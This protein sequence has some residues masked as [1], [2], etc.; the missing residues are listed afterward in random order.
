MRPAHNPD[1][2]IGRASRSSATTFASLIRAAFVRGFDSGYHPD[3]GNGTQEPRN[4]TTIAIK[5]L[6]VSY[7]R[8]WALQNLTGAFAAGA[9][10]AVVGPNGAG[11]STLIKALAGIVR[12]R[13][14]AIEGISHHRR[15]AYLPQQSGLDRGF[16]VT[17]GELV[18]LGG[19]RHFGAFRRAPS[20]IS[21]RAA[22]SIATVGLDGFATRPIAGLSVGQFQRALFA[23]LL[24]QE[25]DVLLLDEPFAAIDERT[26][27][28]LLQLLR[29]WHDEG[30]TI[31]AVLHDLTQVRAHFPMTLLLARRGIG[32]GETASVLTTE[33]L[34]RARVTLEG[35]A[36]TTRDVE[37]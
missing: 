19:W 35:E 24:M 32:W 15:F 6:S 10:T 31:I 11:K 20:E 33:N 34:A 5:D 36:D 30:R 8:Q 18:A 27:E 29:R 26:S 12:T 9:M 3:V 4:P 37:A 17:L 2:T 16:P 7:G 1:L 28:D 13:R 25:A 23:R 22:Q 14:G 21:Q